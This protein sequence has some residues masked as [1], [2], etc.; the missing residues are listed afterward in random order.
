MLCSFAYIEIKKPAPKIAFHGAGPVCFVT[1]QGGRDAAVTRQSAEG[2]LTQN[3]AGMPGFGRIYPLKKTVEGKWRI[4][5]R[6]RERER[7]RART[8][9]SGAVSAIF[10]QKSFFITES[11]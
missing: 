7:E 10:L 4:H 6:E 1:V 3:P 8:V 9:P 5:E 11:W 2:G